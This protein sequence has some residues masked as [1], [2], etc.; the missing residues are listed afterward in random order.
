[1]GIS[2]RF[3]DE[4]NFEIF[5]MKIFLRLFPVINLTPLQWF[6]LERININVKPKIYGVISWADLHIVQYLGYFYEC[7]KDIVIPV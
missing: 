1:M 4:N 2:L 6:F 3:R 7:S 5:E